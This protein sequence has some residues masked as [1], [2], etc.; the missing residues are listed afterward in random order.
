MLCRRVNTTLVNTFTPC[1]LQNSGLIM[2]HIWHKLAAISGSSAVGM[3]AYGAHLLSPADPYYEKV[4]DRGNSMHL[5]AS[6]L[7]G[8]APIAR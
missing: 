3:A 4:F 2:A 6:A 7:L 8:I 5:M 1:G